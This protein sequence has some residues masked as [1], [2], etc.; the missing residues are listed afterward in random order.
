MP[1]KTKNSTPQKVLAIRLSAIGDVAMTVPS[2]W[3]VT[4]NNPEVQV[5]LVSQGFAR[6]IV[7][8]IPGVLFF[9]VDTKKRHKGFFGLI[10]LFNDLKLF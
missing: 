10:R 1:N 8:Q 2:I 9:E 4:Q 3:S 7:D 5:T 6:D